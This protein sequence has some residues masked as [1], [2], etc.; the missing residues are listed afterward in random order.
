MLF[1]I[2]SSDIALRLVIDFAHHAKES[3]DWNEGSLYVP[4]RDGKVST[5]LVKEA[6]P[7][8]CAAEIVFVVMR[9]AVN[10]GRIGSGR[11]RGRDALI[12]VD[13]KKTRSS[14]EREKRNPY[15]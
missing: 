12:G 3:R 1:D 7:V 8:C 4:W 15:T 11:G 10:E 2:H 13:E 9:C 6:D 5:Y 14:V